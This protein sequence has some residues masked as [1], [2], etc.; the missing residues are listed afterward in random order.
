MP[1][2]SNLHTHTT[3]SDG[4]NTVRKYAERAIELGLESFGV[5][6][7]SF[8]P[9][10][11]WTMRLS[12]EKYAE[13]VRAE[14]ER[15]EG[16]IDIF[17]GIEL[18]S[19]SECKRELYD[20]VIASVHFLEHNGRHN[21]VDWWPENTIQIK[22]EYFGGDT[23][24]MCEAYFKA[25]Y[26]HVKRTGPDIVG[27]YD[28]IALYGDVDEESRDYVD[29][30]VG[31]AVETMKWCP[32]FEINLGAVSRGK[33]KKPYPLRPVLEELYKRGGSVVVSSDCHWTAKMAFG[34][35]LATDLLK[36]IGFKTVDRLTKNGFVADEL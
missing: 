15:F 34:F 19:L 30:A 21:A 26:E 32:R 3:M 14:A 35:D 1:I 22:D 10:E 9:G 16:K 7:H 36:D 33:R 25:V 29:L 5:S 20:Y 17:C 23:M 31:Y 24:K 13:A 12:E 4:R 28:L 6:D 8:I 18:D 2:R 27:H 11:D